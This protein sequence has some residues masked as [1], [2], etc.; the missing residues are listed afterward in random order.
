[1]ALL[2]LIKTGWPGLFVIRTVVA[3]EVGLLGSVGLEAKASN[4]SPQQCGD[5]Y[6]DK[7]SPALE[8][9]CLNQALNLPASFFAGAPRYCEDSR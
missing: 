2:S 1:L 7:K 9:P 5:F 3:P 4:K 8:R 6:G